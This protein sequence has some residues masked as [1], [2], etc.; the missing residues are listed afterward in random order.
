MLSTQQT[1]FPKQ[2]SPLPKK[3]QLEDQQQDKPAV[4][5][6]VETPAVEIT[7]E[8]PAAEIQHQQHQ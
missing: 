4:E 7:V 8:T 2:L 3:A 5:I 6:P 1:H